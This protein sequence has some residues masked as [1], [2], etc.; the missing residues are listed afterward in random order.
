MDALAS[1]RIVDINQICF[2][3]GHEE[4]RLLNTYQLIKEDRVL[5]HAPIAMQ[6]NDGRYLI[7]DG[8]HRALALKKLH[9]K[10]LIV[11]LVQLENC[12]L[13]TWNHLLQVG[14]WMGLLKKNPN[15]YFSK[16]IE[17]QY[18]S[19]LAELIDHNGDIHFVYSKA[20]G[21]MFTRLKDWHSI[22]D[23]YN[24]SVPVKRLPQ[25]ES[26]PLLLSGEVLLR[27]PC[28]SAQ[29][30]EKIVLGGQTMPAGVTRCIVEGRLL[31]LRIPLDF[32]NDHIFQQDEWNGL[33]DQW[34]KS[35][36]F[37]SESV[38]LCEV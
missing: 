27:F 8:A 21:E 10:R 17:N 23:S 33:K 4:A 3:E 36:R 2:H 1:L 11:Q 31:N 6:L 15:L 22:V 28:Y 37:Y 9:C 30:L 35:L 38:Y 5:I 25:E 32:L 18:G 34:K 29:Q 26:F 14:E 12:Y 16:K 7:L 24:N 13:G 20:G 19:H